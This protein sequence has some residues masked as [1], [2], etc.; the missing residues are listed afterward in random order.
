VTEFL[1]PIRVYYEDTDSGGVV[2][3]A[4]YLK[5][6]ERARTELL[7][8]T[9][10]E[11]DVL[12]DERQLLF[13]VRHVELDLHQPARFN[14]QL[15]VRTAIAQVH[16]ASISF[17]QSIVREGEAQVL[18]EAAVQVVCI[19]ATDWKPARLPA[20]IKQCITTENP[21]VD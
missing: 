19:N 14:E 4:N 16:G 7:R 17:V 13:V 21:G 8:A 1:W 18:C 6:M 11:Q 2:Y 10:F 20:D 9:G 12:R 3:Y 15:A 5:F